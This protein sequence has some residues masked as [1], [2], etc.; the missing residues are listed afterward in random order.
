MFAAID[1]YTTSAGLSSRADARSVCPKATSALP[2]IDPIGIFQWQGGLEWTHQATIDQISRNES[3]TGK[4][5]PLTVDGR[6]DQHASV[7]ENRAV[8]QPFS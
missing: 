7:I 6:I 2:K 3:G 8:Q 1:P 5:D 4:R